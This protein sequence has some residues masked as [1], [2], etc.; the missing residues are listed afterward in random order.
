MN[1]RSLIATGNT[2][3][4]LLQAIDAQRIGINHGDFSTSNVLVR[5]GRVVAVIDWKF[6]GTYSL[7][8]IPGLMD[9]ISLSKEGYNNNPDSAQAEDLKWNRRV[10]EAIESVARE[11]GWPDEDVTAFMRGPPGILSN[12]RFEMFPRDWIDERESEGPQ[13]S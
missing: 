9:I 10:Q 8:D 4:D 6:A 1:E 11:R 12:A 3:R 2:D 13:T 5:D 7:T